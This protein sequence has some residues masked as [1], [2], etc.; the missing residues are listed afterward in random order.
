MLCRVRE[1]TLKA[2]ADVDNINVRNIKVE[3]FGSYVNGMSTWNSDVDIVITGF[4]KEQRP[5]V[6]SRLS[7][8]V[9][10]LKRNK[11]L[12]LDKIN[13]IS[14]CRIPLIKEDIDVEDLGEALYSF[15]LRY[16]ENFNYETEA[17]SVS[18]EGIVLKEQLDLPA[19]PARPA[20]FV[21]RDEGTPNHMRLVVHCPM[22]GEN[23]TA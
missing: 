13:V 19:S 23:E 21:G 2:F 17:V 22:S 20:R 7:K 4:A 12:K 3:P 1:C 5:R 16:G 8:V 11:N 10:I 18:N 6:A 14:K 15:F 9:S